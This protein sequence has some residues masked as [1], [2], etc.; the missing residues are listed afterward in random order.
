VATALHKTG[1]TQRPPA[2][3]V[4]DSFSRG[5]ITYQLERVRCGKRR[6]KR[7]KGGPAHGPYWYA[8]WWGKRGTA[9]KYIGKTLPPEL[10]LPELRQLQ[11]DDID[12]GC[13]GQPGGS[14]RDC[15]NV[16]DVRLAD[17]GGRPMCASC[18]DKFKRR[19]KRLQL[20]PPRF[21][22]FVR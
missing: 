21:A 14:W 9:T 17:R 16:A 8:Y 19:C 2:R 12:H 11:A 7:C 4:D 6:C 20:P 13:S 10:R 1:G 22:P 3:A 18:A 15:G 5:A